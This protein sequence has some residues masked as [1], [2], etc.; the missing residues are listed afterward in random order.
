MC[1][2]IEKTITVEAKNGWYELAT[3]LC[4]V[5]IAAPGGEYS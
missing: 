1:S 3:K 5:S 2:N 4:K